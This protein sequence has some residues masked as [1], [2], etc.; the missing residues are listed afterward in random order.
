MGVEI[1]LKGKVALVT[2]GTRGIGKS[3]VDQFLL[4]GANVLATGTDPTAIDKLNREN[5]NF[6]LKY[7]QLNLNDSENVKS[8]IKVTLAAESVD[9]LINNAGINIVADATDILDYDFQKIQ[10]INVHGPFL[11]AQAFGKQMIEKKWG[12]IVNIASI[13]SVVTR[14]GRLSYCSSKMALLGINKTLA[15]EWAKHNILVNCISPG[16]TLTE[17]TSKTNTKEELKIIENKIPQNRMALPEEI[18][19]GVLFLSS[20]LNSYITGQNITIDGGYTAI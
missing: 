12:R 9:I 11:L 14:S 8:F 13:W 5:D 6:S 15:A 18:A 4:A 16:F 17:L 2:G 20:E 7:L 19:K 3:I 1:N 10:K